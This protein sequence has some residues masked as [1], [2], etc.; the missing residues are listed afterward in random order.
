MSRRDAL[1]AKGADIEMPPIEWGQ[2][3]I[4]WLFEIGPV[5]PT[6]MGSAPLTGVEIKAWQKLLGVKFQPIE[7]RLLRRLSS[8]YAAAS[9]AATKR[10]CPP[11]FGD[12]PA[13]KRAADREAQRNLDR[14]LA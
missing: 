5:M 12:S 6:G 11:P 7:A 13:L 14:F 1:K 9:Q 2:Y 8:E 3:L 4:D 10:D